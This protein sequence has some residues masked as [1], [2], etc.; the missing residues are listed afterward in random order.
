MD[1]LLFALNAIGPILLLIALGYIL[2]RF[3]FVD[4]HFL[5]YGNKFV[6][7]VAL[8]VMLFYTIYSIKSFKEVNWSIVIYSVF[9][10]MF[11]FTLGFFLALF[12]TKDPKQKGVIIQGV[13]RANYAIIGIPLADA[14][15]GSEA[16]AVVGIVA[17][18]VVP[19]MNILSVIS[20][21]LFVKEDNNDIHPLKTI[22]RKIFANPL[23][24]AIFV[25][26]ATIGIRSFIPI[27]PVTNQHVFTIQ[28][29]IPF[30]YTAIKWI[31]QI[32]SPFALIILGGT[33]EFLTIKNHAKQIILGVVSRVA[34]APLLMLGL[35][36]ILSNKSAFF[37]FSTIEYPALISL[38]ASPTAVSSAIMAK[39][40]KNDEKLAVQIVVWTTTL[41]IISIFII[42]AIFRELSLL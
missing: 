33:F 7:R 5:Q 27:D 9:A 15:G 1:T 35:A 38:I 12:F 3:H 6:F 23:I 8:P 42:V 16:V 37:N 32:A 39:E 41:S 28:N 11:L 34:F 21:V 4:E 18:F 40:M 2:K 10:V 30:L 22:V 29:N 25:G 24:I 31:S 14:I 26:L 19:L 36:V 20:L 13:F 17:A